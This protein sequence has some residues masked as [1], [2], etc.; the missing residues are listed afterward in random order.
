[1]LVT[2]FLFG[3]AN[4]PNPS[5]PRADLKLVQPTPHA[6]GRTEE[7]R[8]FQF[9][10][11]YRIIDFERFG[12]AESLATPA[13]TDG[14]TFDDGGVAI[15][16]TPVPYGVRLLFH[17]KLYESLMVDG[18]RC[19]MIDADGQIKYPAFHGSIDTT[20]FNTLEMEIYRVLKLMPKW[21]PGMCNG[22]TVA[23]EVKRSMTV[24][25]EKGK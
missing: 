22:K 25:L 1:M 4:R 18:A 21:T 12:A 15:K 24:N 10:G 19:T 7:L 13:I 6:I 8:A 9:G 23:G 5:G 2:F 17:N 16:L 3:C 11:I 14:F 20:E